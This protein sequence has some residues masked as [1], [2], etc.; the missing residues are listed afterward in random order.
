MNISIIRRD[1][2]EILCNQSNE[3]EEKHET[4]CLTPGII[5]QVCVCVCGFI[6]SENSS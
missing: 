6:H 1:T 2:Y 5:S 4:V 3:C